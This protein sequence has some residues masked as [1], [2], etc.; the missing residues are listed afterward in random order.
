[1][2]VAFIVLVSTR[3]VVYMYDYLEKTFALGL[4]SCRLIDN[5]FSSFTLFFKEC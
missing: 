4:Q 5:L 2:I 3:S 1:M